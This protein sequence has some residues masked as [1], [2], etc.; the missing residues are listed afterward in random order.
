MTYL[1]V[2]LHRSGFNGFIRMALPSFQEEKRK[3]KLEELEKVRN[4]ERPS[5]CL[6]LKEGHFCDPAH[7]MR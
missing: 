3:R 4:W 6:G 7:H 2:S 1:Q 5:S